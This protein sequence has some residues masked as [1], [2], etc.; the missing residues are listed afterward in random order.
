MKQGLILRPIDYLIN[1]NQIQ[2]HVNHF[3][4]NFQPYIFRK[5]NYFNLCNLL[6][7]LFYFHYVIFLQSY[8][9]H[10]FGLSFSYFFSLNCL[11]LMIDNFYLV[12]KFHLF[13]SYLNHFVV[14][15]QFF[16]NLIVFTDY[17][18]CKFFMLRISIFLG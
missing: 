1:W 12:L 11:L 10:L 2:I 18:I 16:F 14:S 4:Q 6:H 9:N 8:L 15:Y 5:L 13:L 17:F 7:W 3:Y